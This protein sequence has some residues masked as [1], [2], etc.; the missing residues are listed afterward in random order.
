MAFAP[1][2]AGSL[3]TFLTVAQI[4]MGVAGSL[5][6]AASEANAA[7]QAEETAQR[8]KQIAEENA[9]RVL[10][11]AQEEQ[12]QSDMEAAALFGEQEAIQ[13]ASGLNLDSRSFI[14]TRNS[15]R[16]IARQDAINI[17][18][19]AKIRAQAYRTEGD[20]YAADAAAARVAQGNAMIGGLLGSATSIV[21][22]ARNLVSVAP[23]RQSTR[24]TVP[25]PVML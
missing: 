4:G 7:R 8:N 18:E 5:I 10:T 19:A 17:H 15:A 1:A 24:M 6:G 14:Q 11:V 16:A 23:T 21:G 13:A 20:A 9:Q 22:G 3:G 12:Y 2:I 25:S